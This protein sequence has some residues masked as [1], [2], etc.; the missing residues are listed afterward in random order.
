MGWQLEIAERGSVML[1]C[2]CG[3]IVGRFVSAGMG[4][5]QPR[6]RFVRIDWVEFCW[7]GRFPGPGSPETLF[8]PGK[9]FLL[10]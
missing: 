1:H 4:P 3:K 9:L 2:Y 10:E 6:P 7:T 5:A 8:S